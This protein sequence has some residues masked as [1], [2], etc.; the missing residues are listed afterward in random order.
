MIILTLNFVWLYIDDLVGKGLQWQTIT[1]LFSYLLVRL[2][3]TALTLGV[4]IASIM[5]FGSLAEHSELDAI[6]SSG[7]SLLRTFLP[8]MISLSG[9]TAVSI[10]L[11]DQVIPVTNM[12]FTTLLIDITN[13]K[14]EVFIPEGE[15]YN[16]LEGYSILIDAY[17]NE[18]DEITGV[19]I[20]DHHTRK[21][22]K[23]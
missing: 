18:S 23:S 6:R 19:M 20:Y 15:F 5:S 9:I 8:V 14:P 21:T 7:V 2:I 17:N 12:R 11:S 4:L 10:I 16:G 1:E 22:N 3:P 13:K